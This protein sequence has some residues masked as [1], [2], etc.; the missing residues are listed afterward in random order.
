MAGPRYDPRLAD[1]RPVGSSSVMILSLGSNCASP[2]LCINSCALCVGYEVFERMAYYGIASNLVEFLRKKMHEGTVSSANNVT[3]WVG[4]VWM[5]PMLGAYVADAHLGRYWTFIVSSVIYLMVETK[6]SQLF[7]SIPEKDLILSTFD[8]PQG[9]LLLTIVVSVPS[10]SPPSCGPRIKEEECHKHASPLQIGIFYLALYIIAVGT[11]G[12]KPNIST[13]GADQFDDF[14]PTERTQKLSFFNWWMFS[15]FFGTLFSNTFL[16]YVQDNVG[17]PLGYGLPTLGLAISIMVFIFG[18]KYY[19]QKAPVGSPC[20]R[21][22]QVLVAAIKKWRV[23]VPIDPKELYD[24]KLEEYTNSKTFRIDHSNSLRSLFSTSILCF[25]VRNTRIGPYSTDPVVFLQ[26]P[27]QS[28]CKE[29][30]Q[31]AVEPMPSDS[32][33]GNQANDEDAPDSDRVVHP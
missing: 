5:T 3:N 20:T 17:W 19:R 32:S 8:R 24:L 14:E 16:V 7:A 15:I 33:R 22:A 21:I 11:G 18:T 10:L 9:M 31:L 26:A 6:K 28:R 12:T 23:T 4:T 13:M 2:K 27:R 29:W 1:G 25:H 30:L